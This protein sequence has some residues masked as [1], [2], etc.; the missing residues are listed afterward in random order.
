MPTDQKTSPSLT[1]AQAALVAHWS[2]LE[3]ESGLE[4]LSLDMALGYSERHGERRSK[5]PVRTEV[6]P[7]Y[8]EHY[9]LISP[10]AGA[11][12]AG[13]ICWADA[14]QLPLCLLTPDMHNRLIVDQGFRAAGCS[15]TAAMET[16]SVMTLIMAVRDG[17]MSAVLPGA[18]VA[19]ERG[20]QDLCIR[21]LVSPDL[22][23]AI[24]FL[25]QPA[26]TATRALQAAVHLLQS[27][28]WQALCQR[29]AGQLQPSFAN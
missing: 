29:H 19:T 15:V 5:Y 16:N 22:G 28:Q 13:P 18:L 21:P 7:Q 20:A 4:D 6:W 27:P 10:A 23:T 25:V 2:S 14:A 3:L 17:G 26:D 12:A 11:A 1:P 24:A 9:F 8:Q